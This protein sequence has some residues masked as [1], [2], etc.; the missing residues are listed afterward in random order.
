MYTVRNAHCEPVYSK[1]RVA[2]K[3]VGLSVLVYI[4]GVDEQTEQHFVYNE[5]ATLDSAKT[6]VRLIV[7]V[8]LIINDNNNTLLMKTKLNIRKPWNPQ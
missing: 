6:Q 4:E 2:Y 8:L 1:D 3:I 5:H 7:F